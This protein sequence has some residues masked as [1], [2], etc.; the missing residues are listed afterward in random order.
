[1]REINYPDFVIDKRILP[2]DKNSKYRYKLEILLKNNGKDELFV[3]LKN[4]STA[5]IENA[6]VTVSKICNVA[7][8]NGYSKVT[9]FNLFPFKA[10]DAKELLEFF[11]SPEYESEMKKNLNLIKAETKDKDVIIAWGGNS[12]SD[13][14]TIQ[15]KY[16]DVIKTTLD[17]IHPKHIYEVLNHYPLHGQCWRN[18]SKLYEYKR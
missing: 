18:D 15:E 14:K 11:T 1:M 7:N 9:I 13:N 5:N 12:I 8:Y 17:S 16:D 6:D 10:T 3:I 4:P 2:E